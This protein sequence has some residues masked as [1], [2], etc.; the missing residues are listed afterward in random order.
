MCQVV[1]DIIFLSNNKR[2]NSEGSSFIGELS[3][4]DVRIQSLD[5][6]RS[7]FSQYIAG[8]RIPTSGEDLL[9]ALE[10]Y[11]IF[12]HS[13]TSALGTPDCKTTVVRSL[14]VLIKART[15][16]S[17]IHTL[18]Q[19]VIPAVQFARNSAYAGANTII[20]SFLDE[21]ETGVQPQSTP[22]EELDIQSLETTTNVVRSIFDT[23]DDFIQTKLYKKLYKLCLYLLSNGLFEALGLSLE[24][25]NYSLFEQRVLKGK[26]HMGADF[27]ITLLDTSSFLL[28]K[29]YQIV[30][31]G[32][33]NCIFHSGKSYADLYARYEDIRIKSRQLHNPEEFGFK[34]STFRAELEDLLEQFENIHKHTHGMS[35]YDSNKIGGVI[36][37]LWIIKTGLVTKKAA[38]MTRKA[39]FSILLTGETGIGKSYLKDLLFHHFGSFKGLNTSRDFI[40]TRNPASEFWDGFQTYQWCLVMDDLSFMKPDCCPT[41]DQTSMEFIQVINNLPFCPNQASLD[42]KGKTPLQSELVIGTTNIEHLNAHYYFSHPSAIQR[43]FPFIVEPKLKPEYI[44]DKGMLDGEK[45]IFTSG[46]YTD[47]W[48]F[49]VK[50]VIPVSVADKKVKPEIRI[51]HEGLSLKDFLKWYTRCI[52]DFDNNQSKMLKTVDDMKN[53]IHCKYCAMPEYM[54]DC[55]GENPHDLD[56]YKIQSYDTV[57]FLSCVCLMNLVSLLIYTFIMKLYVVRRFNFI[58]MRVKN[59][60]LGRR[61]VFL[62]IYFPHRFNYWSDLGDVVQ[63]N[64]GYPYLLGVLLAVCTTAAVYMRFNRVMR[65]QTYNSATRGSNPVPNETDSTRENVWYNDKYQLSKLDVSLPSL[66]ANGLTMDAFANF[67]GKQC[68]AISVDLPCG[69]GRRIGRA[70]CLKGHVYITNNHNIPD[71][72]DDTHISIVSQS[73]RQGINENFNVKLSK[74]QIYRFPDEDLCVLI[75]RCLPPKRGIFKFLGSSS[76]KGSYNGR[77]VLRDDRGFICNREVSKASFIENANLTALNIVANVW[78]GWVTNPT[79]DGDCGALLLLDTPVGKVVGGFHVAGASGRVLS[80]C[81]TSERCDKLLE[82]F[83][84]FTCSANAPELSAPG[85]PQAI[86]DLNKKS[87]LRYMEEGSA[88]VYGSLAGF[89]AQSRSYVELSPMC[90]FLTNHG[91]KVRFGKPVMSGWL[92]W[93]NALK[94]LADPVTEINNDILVKV[95]NSF[96]LD[97][98]TRL[99]PKDYE[100]LG[101]LT[102]FVA[103]NGAA[104]V[105]YIDKMPRNT[106]AGFP[107]K[108]SKRHF[109]TPDTPVGGTMDPV[110]LDKQVMDRVDDICTK[111]I[112]GERYAPVFVAHLKDEPLPFKKVRSGKTRVFTGAPVDFSFVVRKY[113]LSFVRLVQNKREIFESAPGVIAQSTEWHDLGLYLTQFGPD[114]M[115]AGDYRKFDKKMSPLFMMAAFDIIIDIC[116]SSSLYTAE[117]MA[118]I[119]GIAVDTS[120]P[121]VDFNGDM[122]QFYGSNPSGHPLTVIINGLVNCLYMRYVYYLLNPHKECESFKDNVALMTYGDDNVANVSKR[123]PWYTHTTISEA[124]RT[125]GIDYTMADKSEVSIPY[126]PFSD[127]TFLKRS[128]VWNDETKCWLAP[129]DSESF[130]KMLMVWVRSR[131]ISSEEQII[132]VVTTA[133]REYF[134]YG[135]EVFDSKLKIFR[136]MVT[137]L[138]LEMWV[139]MSTFPS[140]DTLYTDFVR[141]SERVKRL[142]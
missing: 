14:I 91:Y 17:L 53:I 52:I 46:K 10:D 141:N 128:W 95:T 97:I 93:R 114:R 69:G 124:F 89:R 73:S 16:V 44:S 1:H 5:S 76:L 40:H 61:R 116:E 33:I 18:K 102:D 74:S 108:K 78:S 105:N 83:H 11:I 65:V 20:Q 51:I 4:E 98:K 139:E 135:R 50:N 137:L 47:A 103:L 23:Y 109:L 58:P 84:D 134:F 22:S 25:L 96:I 94:D 82:R 32:D 121:L 26:Y 56:P 113:L 63:A 71:V 15:G 99:I 60:I 126:I 129:L 101:V 34:M 13:V 54:C 64:I 67:I 142:K 68:V 6:L 3:L 75:L 85:F 132:D 59:W 43:R 29:G 7:S 86:V 8:G 92:P 117:D 39:P 115:I 107:Y 55:G 31:T 122:V 62:D 133:L 35:K 111:Y 140:W 81:L 100:M 30:K 88:E 66:S 24:T 123:I 80:H 138:E 57:T 28:E 21:V 130:D 19:N 118:I 79:Q 72:N 70:F 112:R 127:V 49:T 131:T 41:G 110:K 119:R 90:S 45:L 87:T 136:E 2:K 36:S 106:S 48:L 9:S 120:Y 37:E 77:L 12:F 42:D 125:I 38:R 104:G 27:V